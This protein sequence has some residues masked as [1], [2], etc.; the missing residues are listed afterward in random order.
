MDDLIR[1]PQVAGSPSN[2]FS[3]TTGFRIAVL[4]WVI[5]VLQ[6]CGMYS[7]SLSLTVQ[8]P[9]APEHWQ[10][11]FPEIDYRVVYPTGEHAGFA[12]RRVSGNAGIIILLP[13]SL[14]LPI[15]AYPNLPELTV[16]LPP[17]GGVYPLDCTTI[18]TI[19]LSWLHGAPAEVLYRLRKNGLGCSSVDVPRLIVEMSARCEGDPWTL[20]LDRICAGLADKTFRMTDIIPAP[21]RTLLVVPGAGSWF[22]ESPFRIPLP[23]RADGSLIL[24]G[25][26]LGAHTL[27]ETTSGASCFL[28]VDEESCLMIRR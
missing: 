2:K 24:E 14:Y 9:P 8:I 13:K 12:E 25:L 20:D 23:A 17:A 3:G 7:S 11:A 5:A 6:A 10:I 19:S 15:L 4:G 28:Y 26:P 22:L 16:E 18:D 21:G 27:F 1:S